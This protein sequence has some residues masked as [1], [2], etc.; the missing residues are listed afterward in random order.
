[1]IDGDEFDE[2]DAARLVEALW[3]Q[4]MADLA[5]MWGGACPGAAGG[6]HAG[7]ERAQAMRACAL[8]RA[9]A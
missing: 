9:Y 7:T 2:D 4:V 5:H 1:M 6:Q 8:G 3:R